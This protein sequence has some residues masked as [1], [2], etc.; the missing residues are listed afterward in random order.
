MK[1]NK[2]IWLMV[3][4]LFVGQIVYAQ[5]NLGAKPRGFDKS[6]KLKS[7]KKTS[8]TLVTYKPTES[9][10]KLLKTDQHNDSLGE[11]HRFAYPIS[12]NLGE[13]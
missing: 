4:S 9:I 3:C 1:M 6:L 5:I 7:R 8:D 13:F 12:V 2:Y 11:S 10:D